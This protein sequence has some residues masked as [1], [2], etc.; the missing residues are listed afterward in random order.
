LSIY[1]GTRDFTDAEAAG[2]LDREE[3]FCGT[4]QEIK[5][6]FDA[7]DDVTKVLNSWFV[8]HCGLQRV[9]SE[10]S[11]ERRAILARLPDLPA[12]HL[13]L[14]ASLFAE[15]ALGE[16]ETS[17][18]RALE[19]G[20]PLPGLVFNYLACLAARRGDYDAMMD[21]YTEAAETD[22]Q[23]G[24]LIRNVNAAR[25]WFKSG[26]PARGEALELTPGHDFQ[27]LERTVQP[28]LPGPLP[29]DFADFSRTLEPVEATAQVAPIGSKK[30]LD[31][32]GKLNVL[33]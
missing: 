13:D 10:S 9:Y 7:P 12:A 1:P 17:C 32:R 25:A 5:T 11:S 4:F 27:L 3:Y 6:P 22:P 21:L 24:L 30:A 26:G 8:D 29:D 33:R 19:L 23:H 28:T 16:A 15:G 14:A 2:W 18:R 20:H 31:S